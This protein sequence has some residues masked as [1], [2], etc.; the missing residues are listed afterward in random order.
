[1]PFSNEVESK[2]RR[3]RKSKIRDTISKAVSDSKGESKGGPTKRED[4][5][6]GG[7]SSIRATEKPNK[8]IELEDRPKDIKGK[9]QHWGYHLLLDCSECNERIDDEKAVE[10]FL[11]QLV[12]E[13]KMK[14]IG[15][16]I[17]VKVDSK[18]EGRGISGVQIIESSTITA[19]FD[20]EGRAAYIDVFS[21]APYDPEVAIKCVRKFFS[22]KYVGD[23]WIERDAADWPKKKA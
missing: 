18:K 12:K 23:L 19:H 8:P 16:P 15:D 4:K 11:K 14:P 7:Y 1:M 6:Q 2:E 22:P 13:I 3:E 20:D 21:C 10:N 9:G 5:S 17:I